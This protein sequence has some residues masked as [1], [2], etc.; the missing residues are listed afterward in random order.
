M[1]YIIYFFQ[2]TTVLDET[3][4]VTNL[5][6]N[7][8]FLDVSAPPSVLSP[9]RDLIPIKSP[10]SVPLVAENYHDVLSVDNNINEA[11]KSC[12]SPF[13]EISGIEKLNSSPDR[14]FSDSSISWIPDSE[15]N[16][17]LK[18][19][20]RL[21]VPSTS[22]NSDTDI[23]RCTD[24]QISIPR[25]TTLSSCSSLLFSK[26]DYNID[27]T[28]VNDPNSTQEPSSTSVITS[29][30]VGPTHWKKSDPSKWKRN[31]AKFF[32]IF[33]PL[34]SEIGCAT[35]SHRTKIFRK[36]SHSHGSRLYA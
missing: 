19:K 15:E 31:I 14:I 4:L 9:N 25:E 28:A 30:S 16:Y 6:L 11:E 3:K 27:N 32:S 7:N 24:H 12:D 34:N 17:R 33:G 13:S 5:F 1:N 22:S 20:T 2:E 35:R 18:K 26:I 36:W 8:N 10:H 21:I 23:D 29:N